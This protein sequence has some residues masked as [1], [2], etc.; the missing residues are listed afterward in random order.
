MGGCHL[1]ILVVEDEPKVA[2][3]IQEGLE[4]ELYSV[5]VAHTGEDGFFLAGSGDFDLFVLDVMLPG[6]NGIEVLSAMR[7]RGFET[8]VLLL[9]AKDAIEDRVR[10]LDAGADDYLVKPFAFSEFLARIRA[11]LRRGKRETAGVLSFQDLHMDRVSRKVRRGPQILELTP[12]EFDL[13]EY[14]LEHQ[15]E[16]VSREMIERDVWKAKARHTPLDNVIDVHMVRL[17]RKVDEGFS[18]KLVH[19]IRGVGFMVG[20]EKR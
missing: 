7:K 15:G 13:L 14:L 4:A 19:T 3:A 16:T 1:R 9:T 10:G 17:R 8:P 5:T 11:L 18:R 12:K 20:T 2:K 6:R